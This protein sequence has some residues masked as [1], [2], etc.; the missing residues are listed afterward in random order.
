MDLS[1]LLSLIDNMPSFGRL[2]RD[3]EGGDGT[4]RA[5]LPDTA[6]PYLSA[7]LYYKMRRPLLVITAQPE[8]ARRFYEQVSAWCG[9]D[10]SVLLFP[11]LDVL[12]YERLAPSLALVQERLRVLSVLEDVRDG[13]ESGTGAVLIIASAPAVI[14]KTMSR[15][16]FASAHHKLSVGMN[17]EPLKLL[18]KWMDMGYRREE[19]VELPGTV[20]RRGGILDIYSPNND[21]PARIEFFGS[22]IESIRFFDPVTQRSKQLT[23]S[24]TVVPLGNAPS[25]SEEGVSG[26]TGTMLDYLPR[27]SMLILDEAVEIKTVV[28][29]VDVRASQL[30][31]RVEGELPKDCPCPYLTGKE[32]EEKLSE[33]EKRLT[34]ARW[35]GG[36]EVEPQHRHSL[37]FFS[38]P[39]YGGQLG[40]FLAGVGDMVKGKRRLIIISYQAERL[41]Q[42]LA[43]E[44]HFVSPLSRIGRLPPAGSLTL[45]EGS[46]SEGWTMGRE[47]VVTLL[48]DAELFGFSKPRRQPV[49][50]TAVREMSL[51]DFSLGDY[52]VHIEHGIGRVVGVTRMPADGGEREY[53]VLEYAAGD[54][55][56]VPVDQIDRI[57][58]YLG[59][60]EDSP[61][62][63]RLGTQ[64]WARIRR[65]V[66]ESTEAMARELLALYAEREVAPGFAFSPDNEWQRELE[67]SFPYMETPDQLE[68]VRKV[69]EDMEQ[70]KCMDRLVCGDV[71]Y[72]KTEVILRA[73]F[74]AVMDGKQ[75]ALL[76]PTT[77]LAQQHLI[78]FQQRLAMFPVR[79]EMLSRFNSRRE[80]EETIAGLAGGTVDICIGTHR[81]LQKDVKF[82]NLGLVVVDEEQRF[83]VADKERLKQMRREVDIL[84]SSATPI[85][86]TLHMS[87]VG[88]RDISVMET[89]PED[90]LPIKTCV[91]EYNE[92]LIREAVVREMERNGQVFF[93]HNR[94]QNISWIAH[95]LAKLVPEARIVVAHGQ[96]A[97]DELKSAMLKFSRG[98]ADVLVCTTIIESGLD[99]PNANTLV[100]NDADG[101]GLAQLYQLRGRVGRCGE[102]AYAHFLYNLGK[103]LTS[104][105]EKRL[106]TIF[107]A[108]ELGA[109]FRIAMKDLEIR[110]AGNLL[111]AEQSGHVA[112]V[113]FDLYCRLLADSVARLRSERG[114]TAG[115]RPQVGASLTLE[116]R[117]PTINLPIPAR[118]PEDYVT[119][120]DARLALY[121]RLAAIGSPEEVDNIAEE[122]RD[123]FGRMPFPVENLLYIVRLKT[124]A[125][126]A[127][128][129]SISTEGNYIVL[130]L[131]DGAG[132]RLSRLANI[133][134]K[135]IRWDGERL[136]LRRERAGDGW[137]QA[138]EELL[139]KLSSPHSGS[140]AGEGQVSSGL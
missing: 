36:G 9:S 112:A 102:R 37:E 12:P 70:P 69:K 90:R 56:Y 38:A 113:G 115:E 66:K 136:M 50:P 40:P 104:A 11:D 100:I 101:L 103:H 96:M 61:T 22:R 49:R 71:G 24:V 35:D 116:S 92:R 110:G 128:I 7:A 77:V 14:R 83:G 119:D 84:T 44:E 86:R 48:T 121:R 130:R 47:G 120:V 67:A 2:A 21:L 78:T 3:L 10:T 23:Q 59:S 43:E 15:A 138:L 80:Q 109:G 19:E 39:H 131:G 106:G 33:M 31:R 139:E 46:L 123:R 55:L 129:R 126:R 107:E 6:K 88:V 65:K 16:E 63:T 5:V 25:S 54:R 124:L 58:R 114:R 28:E 99:I 134:E 27:D 82:K 53:I 34:L 18:T 85:P 94:V 72:G 45:L 51:A 111:G 60:G 41:S 17:A 13:A 122:F 52:V 20:S 87:L 97:G 57:S 133:T 76:V 29:E 117:M 93:V 98:D 108:T 68:A 64:E 4:H 79:V 32:L 89:P 125:A 62:L 95:R 118:I 30:R 140:S 75:V 26:V 132:A 74:K 1:Y 105:A 91:A 135:T 137:R 81:L 73:A 127:N 8:G 42:L